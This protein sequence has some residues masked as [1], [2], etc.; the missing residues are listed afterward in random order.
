MERITFC[1]SLAV[2]RCNLSHLQLHVHN[3]LHIHVLSHILWLK[4]VDFYCQQKPSKNIIRYQATATIRRLQIKQ[5]CLKW[6]GGGLLQN[7]QEHHIILTK[8]EAV[9]STAVSENIFVL[10]KN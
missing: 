4:I 3:Y 5:Y 7:Q 9:H 1:V 10:N 8:Y 6:G 2:Y